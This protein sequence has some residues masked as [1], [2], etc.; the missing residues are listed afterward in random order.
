MQKVHVSF[1]LLLVQTGHEIQ[2]IFGSVQGFVD[3]L[4]VPCTGAAEASKC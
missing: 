4:N 3:V 1:Q 2:I